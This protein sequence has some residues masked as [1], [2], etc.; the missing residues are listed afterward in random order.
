VS[1][2]LSPDARAALAAYGRAHAWTPAHEERVQAR[3]EGSIASAAPLAIDVPRTIGRVAVALAVAAGVVLAIGVLAQPDTGAPLP[4]GAPHQATRGTDDEKKT[5]PIAPS[6]E[7]PR[8]IVP[9]PP[10]DSPPLVAPRVPEATRAT[11]PTAPAPADTLAAEMKLLKR[12][13]EALRD[14]DPS[15]ALE[16]LAAH[17]ERHPRGQMAE[18]RE[19]LRVDVLCR[20][21]RR[22]EARRAA[23]SFARRWPDSPHAA[24]VAKVCLEP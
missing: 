8:P 13:R 9:P 12:A 24:R 14:D 22:D 3:I 18:D 17:A 1:D 11:P 6:P 16:H 4:I 7:P 5:E 23:Q 2:E 19:A 15:A 10:V 20:A 21:E